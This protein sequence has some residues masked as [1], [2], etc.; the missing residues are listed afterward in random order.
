[1]K[2]IANLFIVVAVVIL[3]VA[4]ISRVTM[5]PVLGVKAQSLLILTNTLLL[6][7][8]TIMLLEQQKK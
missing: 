5:Q 8:I 4:A 1:M 2:Q 6:L 7:G 3:L